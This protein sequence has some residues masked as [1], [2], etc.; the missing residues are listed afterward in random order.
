MISKEELEALVAPI[1]RDAGAELVQVQVSAGARRAQLRVFA[2][3]EGGITVGECGDLSRRIARELDRLA[4]LATGYMLE[5]SSPGM[6][7]PIWAL[8][9]YR[10]FAGERLSFELAEPYEG[11]RRFAGTI[12]SVE[13]ERI[14]LRIAGGDLLDVELGQIAEARLDMDPW[15]RRELP[16]ATGGSAPGREQEP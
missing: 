3:R 14:R 9:H 16:R 7:R 1:L 8:E 15:K 4:G 6:N 11:R 10:R 13:G 2:D 5:V 12:E